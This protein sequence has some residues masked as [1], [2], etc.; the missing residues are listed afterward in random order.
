VG[1]SRWKVVFVEATTPEGKWAL[2]VRISGVAVGRIH[3]IDGLYRYFRRRARK[4]LHESRDLHALM[5]LVERW[6]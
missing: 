4:A 5:H 1:V 2:E 6:P 3:R